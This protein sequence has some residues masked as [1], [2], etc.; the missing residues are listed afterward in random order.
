MRLRTIELG[1]GNEII[2]KLD[3]IGDKDVY[4][5]SVLEDGEYKF[6][7]SGYFVLYN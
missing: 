5:I 7:L 6:F 3:H 2:G 4:L 1:I